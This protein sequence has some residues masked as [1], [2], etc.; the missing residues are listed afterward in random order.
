MIAAR[1]IWT[2]LVP[3]RQWV[4][5][6]RPLPRNGLIDW[7]DLKDYHFPVMTG[8]DFNFWLKLGKWAG[9]AIVGIFLLGVAALIAGLLVGIS[10]LAAHVRI[11]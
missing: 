2:Y 7:K 6:S 1:G 8:S 10:W 3:R 4:L 5:Q 9:W 11:G